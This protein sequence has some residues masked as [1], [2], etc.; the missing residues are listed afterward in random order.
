MSD[1]DKNFVFLLLGHLSKY[2]EA[3]TITSWAEVRGAAQDRASE[4]E[5]VTALCTS[6]RGEF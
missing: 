3:V 4:Q 6:W 5:K 2:Y 1:E